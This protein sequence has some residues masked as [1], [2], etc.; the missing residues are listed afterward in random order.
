M[1][2][3]AGR[4]LRIISNACKAKPSQSPAATAL[5]EGE[6]SKAA[7]FQVYPANVVRESLRLLRKPFGSGGGTGDPSPTAN[8]L[9]TQSKCP[10]S[11][12]C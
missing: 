9:T 10:L 11:Q 12:L 3:H 8:N 7:A 1:K 5:P 2:R 6:P 4:S